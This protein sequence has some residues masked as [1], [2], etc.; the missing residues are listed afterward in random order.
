MR[1]CW[2]VGLLLLLAAPVQ[3]QTLDRLR[4]ANTLHC[5]AEPRPGFADRDD[6]NGAVTGLAMD[7]CRAIAIA[8]LGPLGKVAFATPE[9]GNTFDAIRSGATEISFLSGGTITDQ[10][11]MAAL[12]PG[13]V[14][15]VDPIGLMVPLDSPIRK[16]RD[17][18]GRTVCLMIG[19]A[20]QRALEAFV[21]RA[22]IDIIRSTWREDV[23][24][25]DTYNSANCDALVETATRL[26]EIRAT[27]SINRVRS[28]LLDPPLALVPFLAAVPAGDST[29]ARLVFWTLN[30]L[31]SGEATPWRAA[32]AVS[33]PGLREHWREDVHAA[34]GSYADMR[35]RA[36][37]AGAWP[38]A[39]WPEGVL[40]PAVGE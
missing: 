25:M 24:M 22:G 39:P 12:L 31:I 5:A 2:R 38:N 21:A 23:E 1:L 37:G 3:A 36:L 14:V 29:W 9:G 17:I 26:Q 7:L 19:S 27:P 34:L 18:A 40:L 20:P 13:P 28:R 33:L 16:P 4:Q 15:F 6:D 11:L 8:T 32:Q 10:N 30:A 35:T